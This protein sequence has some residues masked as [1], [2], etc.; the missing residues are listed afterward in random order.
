MYNKDKKKNLEIIKKAMGHYVA[1]L[2]EELVPDKLFKF[3]LPYVNVNVLPHRELLGNDRLVQNIDWNSFDR[4]KI[5]TLIMRDVS[6]FDKIDLG[7]Y[8][9][10]M[11]EL[12]PLFLYHPHL[13]NSFDI[14]FD[15]LTPIE[16]IRMLEVNNNFIDKID[17]GKYNYDKLQIQEIVKKFYHNENIINKLNLENLDHYSVRKLL[18]KTGTKHVDRLNLKDLKVQDWI[19]ILS[20]KPELLDNCN[21]LLFETNDCYNLIKL[22]TLFPQLDYMIIENKEKFSPLGWEELIIKD[23]DKY[24]DM[25]DISKL[26]K[27]NWDNIVKKHP[28]LRVEM[29]KYFID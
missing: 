27:K 5:I 3:L 22:V 29:K 10:T 1:L 13:I 26:S 20:K 18:I 9:F 2:D 25:C 16:A 11:K 17:L 12:V 14:N 4:T 8:N 23:P 15:I 19:D 7:R 28:I 21:L 24:L 6:V